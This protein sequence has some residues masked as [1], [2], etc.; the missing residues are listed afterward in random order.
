MRL[1]GDKLTWVIPG[2][3]PVSHCSRQQVPEERAGVCVGRLGTNV[4][5]QMFELTWESNGRED[6]TCRWEAATGRTVS[7]VVATGDVLQMEGN[8]T[9]E[10]ATEGMNLAE[11]AIGGPVVATPSPP[12]VNDAKV[13]AV[14]EE[15]IFEG[16]VKVVDEQGGQELEPNSFSP[17][18]V[19]GATESLP[20]GK[21]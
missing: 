7:W 17:A 3:R 20:S 11:D 5:K 8:P 14:D 4:G 1:V 15:V 12:A 18:D 21:Q 13:I 2:G 9:T 10:L 6:E 16:G 19:A